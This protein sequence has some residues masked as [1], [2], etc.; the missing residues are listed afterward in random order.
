MAPGTAVPEATTPA[1]R[2]PIR[3]NH[4]PINMTTPTEDNDPLVTLCRMPFLH[5][6]RNEGFAERCYRLPA[7]P[8]DRV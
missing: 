8:A 1:P 6:P 7:A 5:R 3:S 4:V 2:M